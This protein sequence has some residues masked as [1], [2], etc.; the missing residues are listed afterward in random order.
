[1]NYVLQK[2]KKKSKSA[3]SQIVE[4][5]LLVLIVIA[6]VTIVSTFAINFVKK[7]LDKGNCFDLNGQVEI[8]NNPEYTCYDEDTDEM[9]VQVWIGEKR[10]VIDA[11]KIEVGGAD[12]KIY[13]IPGGSDYV[14][15]GGGSTDLPAANT[16]RT[17]VLS[18]LPST[19]HENMEL[20]VYAVIDNDGEEEICDN[21]EPV[22]YITVC[23]S[24]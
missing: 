17:Y 20:R 14:G 16:E 4:T 21:F 22:N 6:V 9:R 3:Q 8:K 10:D 24:T 18:N 2:N 23:P 5:L 13:N 7:Q 19:D 11:I 1:M 15:F 12:S